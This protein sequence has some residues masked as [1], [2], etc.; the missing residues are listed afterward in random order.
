MAGTRK[1]KNN[2]KRRK[3]KRAAQGIGK[4]SPRRTIPRDPYGLGAE[5]MAAAAAALLIGGRLVQKP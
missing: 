4:S 1:H 2:L 3:A 5:G